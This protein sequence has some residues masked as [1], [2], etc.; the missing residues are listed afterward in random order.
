MARVEELLA[1]KVLAA[2]KRRPQDEIDFARLIEFNP[3][4]DEAAVRANLSLIMAR[5]Y[6]RGEDLD[7]K[8]EAC[9][10]R[11]RDVLGE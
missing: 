10:S 9:L 4:Y 1:T 7:Q 3:D 6:S 11:A 2:A 8:L 5:G